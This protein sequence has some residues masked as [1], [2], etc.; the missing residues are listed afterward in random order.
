MAA[1]DP[2]TFGGSGLGSKDGCV[3][4]S[5]FGRRT[6]AVGNWGRPQSKLPNGKA[7]AGY[8]GSE[9]R[10]LRRPFDAGKPTAFISES[11]LRQLL[12]TCSLPWEQ[13]QLICEREVP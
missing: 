13:W 1:Y 7:H 3:N 9:G 2:L 6:Y 4:A 11:R 12:L 10:C 5:Q 8:W